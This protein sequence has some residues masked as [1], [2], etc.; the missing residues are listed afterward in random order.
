M[1]GRTLPETNGGEVQPMPA[2]T[3]RGGITAVIATSRAIA[4]PQP[5]RVVAL[6]RMKRPDHRLNMP[7]VIPEDKRDSHL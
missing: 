5:Y 1:A 6:G 7:F 4:I 2:F 3:S